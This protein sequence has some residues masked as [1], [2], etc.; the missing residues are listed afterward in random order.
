LAQL[1]SEGAGV[2]TSGGG[3]VAAAA[4]V[5]GGSEAFYDA[6]VELAVS[7]LGDESQQS[8]PKKSRL[9]ENKVITGFIALLIVGLLVL[10]ILYLI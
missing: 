9:S 1:E 10:I 2:A 5:G 7:S 4:A 3:D 8:A 6:D